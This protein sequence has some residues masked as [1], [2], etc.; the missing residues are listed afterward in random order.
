MENKQLYKEDQS[1]RGIPVY[2][3]GRENLSTTFSGNH[4][5]EKTANNGSSREK[6]LDMIY[7]SIINLKKATTTLKNSVPGFI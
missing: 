7:A 2:Q 6:G 5:F 4:V 3:S 1:N